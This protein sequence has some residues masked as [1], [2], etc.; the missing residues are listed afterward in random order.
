MSRPLVI[1]GTGGGVYD[2]LDIVE[3]INLEHPSWEPI[4]FLDDSRPAGSQYLGLEI[5]GGLRDAARFAGAAFANAIGSDRT[6]RR[7]PGILA[8]T[9]VARSRFATLIHP[10]ASISSRARIGRGVVAGP[11]VV[12]GGGVVTGDHVTLCPGCIIGHESSIGDHCIVAPGS[13]ISGLVRIE[14]ACYLG[15]RSVVRQ[16]LRIGTGALIGMGAVVVR[17]VE[18]DATVVGNPA[19]PLDRFDGA[20]VG[21][22]KSHSRC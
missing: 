20:I 3:A 12:V 1:L 7:L 17:D 18:P 13:T 16:K 6:F 10:A 9:G 2:L 15:A 5:L 8:S 21:M 19:R 4:G 11:G 14:P 22:T